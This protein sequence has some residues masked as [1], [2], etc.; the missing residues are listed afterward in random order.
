MSVHTLLSVSAPF[1]HNV[2][3][4]WAPTGA[5]AVEDTLMLIPATLELIAQVRVTGW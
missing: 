2:T 4:Q 1:R 5:P 3:T